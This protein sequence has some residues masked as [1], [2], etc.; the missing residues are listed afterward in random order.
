MSHHFQVTVDYFASYH[1]KSLCDS[2]FSV[3]TSI[4]EVHSKR[5]SVF[6]EN[7]EDLIS[8]LRNGLTECNRNSMQRNLHK[9]PTTR[10]FLINL[11]IQQKKK[12]MIS[13]YMNISEIFQ[14]DTIFYWKILSYLIIS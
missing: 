11:T 1:G 14:W 13:K 10:N 5:E 7:T 3:L 6:V 12:F 9:K 2:W 8:L 4:Y